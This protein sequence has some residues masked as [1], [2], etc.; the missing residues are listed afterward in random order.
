MTGSS[1]VEDST[2]RTRACRRRRRP[3]HAHQCR[4]HSRVLRNSIPQHPLAVHLLP[5]PDDIFRDGEASRQPYTVR[6][7][8]HGAIRLV[9]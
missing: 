8:P 2:Q 5:D 7:I 6:A 9:C 4:Q 1:D 3:Y